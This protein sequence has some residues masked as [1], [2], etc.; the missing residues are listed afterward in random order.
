M[1]SVTGAP[2]TDAYTRALAA[3]PRLRTVERMVKAQVLYVR[4]ADTFCHGCYWDGVLK[5]LVRPLIGWNRGEPHEDAHPSGKRVSVQIG[6]DG[7][8]EEDHGDY[9][10]V[11][12]T[13]DEFFAEDK[14]ATEPSNEVEA[15]LRCSAAW[16]VVTQHLLEILHRADPGNGHGFAVEP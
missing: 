7:G 8:G 10:V 12:K 6:G 5:P 3:E 2:Q 16:D 11:K 4:P 1:E 14:D 13:W 9:V 15:W